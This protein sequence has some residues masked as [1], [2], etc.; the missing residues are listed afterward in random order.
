MI[1]QFIDER[2][3]WNCHNIFYFLTTP[4]D[5]FTLSISLS[6]HK[7]PL[8][9]H[10]F[11]WAVLVPAASTPSARIKDIKMAVSCSV[12]TWRGF[13]L[14]FLSHSFF[15][16]FCF[17]KLDVPGMLTGS[18]PLVPPCHCWG[19]LSLVFLFRLSKDNW[20]KIETPLKTKESSENPSVPLLWWGI[21]FLLIL[22]SVTSKGFQ[23]RENARLRP[24]P[25]LLQCPEEPGK[26]VGLLSFFF[27]LSYFSAYFFLY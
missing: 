25:V 26:R 23:Q 17:N 27:F 19:E 18:C 2:Q 5:N 20:Q 9:S 3:E 6:S 15:F 4:P 13:F 24:I 12:Q 22:Y 21:F 10:S 1:C 16:F 14:L 8:A 11:S 7:S